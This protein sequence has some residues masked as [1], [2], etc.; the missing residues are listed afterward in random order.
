[1]FR[2]LQVVFFTVWMSRPSAQWRRPLGVVETSVP[3]VSRCSS[4]RWEFLPPAWIPESSKNIYIPVFLF[5]F[6]IFFLQALEA[7]GYNPV[8]IPVLDFAF[9]N[10]D[11]LQ[12]HLQEPDNHSG[13]LLTSPRAAEAIQKVLQQS[14]QASD[15]NGIVHIFK[16]QAQIIV[17]AF[18][19]FSLNSQNLAPLQN[20]P[21]NIGTRW[22][23]PLPV[24]TIAATWPIRIIKH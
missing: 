22:Q 15:G 6:F 17:F 11:K 18:K 13:L 7:V 2:P 24:V 20:M 10:L 16:N 8:C 3:V 23:L 5:V 4:E 1:M 14:D 12:H 19:N 9:V 21:K